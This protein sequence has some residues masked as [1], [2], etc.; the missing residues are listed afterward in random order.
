MYLFLEPVGTK[1]PS[2]SSRSKTSSFD[3]NL[4]SNLALLCPAQAMP[5]PSYR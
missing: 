1:A 3:F 5:V 2:F 4:G